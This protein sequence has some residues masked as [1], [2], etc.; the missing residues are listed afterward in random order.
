MLF[1]KSGQS[2]MHLESVQ[3]RGRTLN[4][5]AW[6]YDLVEP[7]VMMGKQ[8]EINRLMT[9][10]LEI[11]ASD[12]ILDIGCG[13]GIVTKAVSMP[14][15]EEEGGFAIGIDAAAKMIQGA[16]K[17]RQTPVCRFEVAAAE[18]LP[19]ENETFDTAVSSLFFH[20]VQR[21]LKI[22]ALNEAHRV[23]KPGGRMIV[24]DMHTPTSFMGAL[25]SHVSRWFFL[26]PQ[27]GENIRGILPGLIEN[28][29]FSKPE[30]IATYLGYISVFNCKKR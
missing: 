6:V 20:H 17:K 18:K 10:L 9:E 1:F 22:K 25:T 19:F 15:G 12:R 7:L 27:I 13:T 21:D 8:A 26:Q 5:A 14:L 3:T 24:C 23:L 16:R 30:N 28:A 29:G 11:K 4:H 2:R